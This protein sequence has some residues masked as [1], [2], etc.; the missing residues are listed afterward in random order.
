MPNQDYSAQKCSCFLC[1]QAKLSH[2][3]H[4]KPVR[5]N[6]KTAAPKTSHCLVRILV[7]RHNWAVFLR[8]GASTGRYI[9]NGDRYRTMLNEFLF[10]KIK[11]RILA[12]FGFNRTALRA[13]QPKLQSI[14]CARIFKTALSAAELMLFGHLWAAI[15]HRW[16][17]IYGKPSKTGVTPTSQRQLT[18]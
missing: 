16:T 10:T 13:T 15:W 7:Q 18:L 12:T 4:R 9:Y 2:L 8:K 14:F 1:K 11:S 17:I 3:W 5:I 6:W